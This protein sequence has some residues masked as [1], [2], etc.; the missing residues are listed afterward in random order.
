MKTDKL[1]LKHIAPYL[2]YGLKV[3]NKFGIFEVLGL[4]NKSNSNNNVMLA[5]KLHG[6]VVWG[7]NYENKLLL[8]PMT[9]LTEP[10]E[11][12]SVP[13]LRISDMFHLTFYGKGTCLDNKS[14]IDDGF[15]DGIEHSYF[16]WDDKNKVF[17]FDHFENLLTLESLE[18]LF[19]NHFDVFGLI[20]KGLALAK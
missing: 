15:N 17:E 4:R 5:F 1:E 12:G 7:Y 19:K 14:I 10:L 16:F 18:Y 13:L 6:D 8:R 11:D 9:D 2:P 3:S 20:D